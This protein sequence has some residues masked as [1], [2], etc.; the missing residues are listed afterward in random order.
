MSSSHWA[1]LVY[2]PQSLRNVYLSFYI[3]MYLKIERIDRGR[4]EDVK[5]YMGWIPESIRDNYGL[6]RICTLAMACYVVYTVQKIRYMY[7]QKW[8]CAASFPISTFMYDVSVSNLYILRIGL[9]I[10]P[11]QSR[12]LGIYKSLTDKW[13]WK[14]GDRTS[15]F[16]FG[17][18]VFLGIHKLEPDIYIGFS[19]TRHL[20][21]TE[22]SESLLSHI[23]IIHCLMPTNSPPFQSPSAVVWQPYS[24]NFSIYLRWP[25][26]ASNNEKMYFAFCR[27][28]PSSPQPLHH[29]SV[30]LL[31]VVSL[32]LTNTVSR[33]RACLSI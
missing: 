23:N 30:C 28:Y 26:L 18:N 2:V 31:P 13:M 14:L 29:S 3:K 33:V 1:T 21:C 22:Y 8:N 15:Q 4:W 25:A 32:L 27:L 11:Q 9:P 17:N 12:L 5:P 20:Q 24:D 7:S 19:L 10:W 6:C 16:C